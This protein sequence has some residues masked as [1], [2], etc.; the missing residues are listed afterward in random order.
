MRPPFAPPPRLSGRRTTAR[1]FPRLLRARAL[2]GTVVRGVVGAL[3]IAGTL[4][5]PRPG[6]AQPSTGAVQG[7]A[8]TA[9]D[10]TPIPFALVRVLR[11][12][13]PPT[14]AGAVVQ[15]VVTNA[16]GRFHVAGVPTGAYQLQLARIGHQ[17]VLSP[18]LRVEG[19]QTTR[20]DL[21]AASR[22][23]QLAAVRVSGEPGCRTVAQLDGD[24]RLAALWEEA[25]KGVE[26]RLAFERQYRFTRIV[27]Q[28]GVVRFRLGRRGIHRADTLHFEPD[29]VEVWRLRR[30]AETRARGHK[31]SGGK[32][33]IPNEKSLLDPEYMAGR[34]LEVV[35]A[36]DQADG[37]VDA[38]AGTIGL[39]FRPASPR[40]D[41]VD[42]DGILWLDARD[43]LTRRLDVRWLRGGDAIARATLRYGDVP[44]AGGALRMSVG[45]TAAMTPN[46]LL[47]KAILSGA[48]VTLTMRYLDF[49]A[50]T[51]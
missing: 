36:D 5:A 17:L 32:L 11:A 35:E 24:P 10:A 31:E 9:E 1:C 28:D 41:G 51:R 4:V 42:L 23:L 16:N 26:T 19:G 40:T 33:S 6:V 43:F 3:A 29:S 45:G 47:A 8:V 30:I 48:D 18:V 15:Q 39:R 21:R 50:V 22:V 14:A 38:P 37:A 7:A 25:R 13:A 27:R 49:A 44:V 34:C 12:D 2:A 20:H 46:V